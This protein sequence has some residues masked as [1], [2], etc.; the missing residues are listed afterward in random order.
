MSP[1]EGTKNPSDPVVRLAV[2]EAV[3]EREESDT[4]VVVMK[5]RRASRSS[6]ESSPTPRKSESIRKATAVLGA[7]VMNE[8]LA[9][10]ETQLRI[11]VKTR[12]DTFM[13]AVV[14]ANI[15]VMALMTQWS[16]RNSDVALDLAD[17]AWPFFTQEFFDGLEYVSRWQR[18]NI[19]GICYPYLLGEII[20]QFDDYHIFGDGWF[21]HQPGLLYPL[22]DRCT[23][24]SLCP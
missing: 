2:P 6:D 12:L 11:F 18:K 1:V 21:N 19:F 9:S 16:G 10:D 17:E 15:T 22:L 8:K 4:E 3:V 5:N 20:I 14:F 24:E 23:P 7:K 13:G